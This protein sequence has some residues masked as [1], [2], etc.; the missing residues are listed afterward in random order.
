MTERPPSASA[1]FAG[2]FVGAHRA[3]VTCR[4]QKTKC[5]GGAP[6][7]RCVRLCIASSCKWVAPADSS[8]ETGRDHKQ[9]E[10]ARM[11]PIVAVVMAHGAPC[12][13][14]LAP[15]VVLPWLST[16]FKLYLSWGCDRE[17]PAALAPFAHFASFTSVVTEDIMTQLRPQSVEC[18]LAASLRDEARAFFATLT[19]AQRSVM[20]VIARPVTES[21]LER[22]LFES[23]PWGVITRCIMPTYFTPCH[24]LRVNATCSALLGWS[25]VDLRERL[26]NVSMFWRVQHPVSSAGMLHRFWGA[27]RSK[28]TGFTRNGLY[29]TRTGAMAELVETH[30]IRWS[31]TGMPASHLIFLRPVSH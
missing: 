11:T 28:E 23:A 15:D 6:C 29:Y 26:S 14:Y 13:S 9:H 18:R 12:N 31:P 20:K 4:R 22:L 17:D 8:L 21:V 7:A 25:A 16:L 3:C 10:S 2:T 5:Q 24:A 27:V 30:H 19:A 1:S